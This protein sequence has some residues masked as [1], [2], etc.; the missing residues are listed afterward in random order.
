MSTI[1][2]NT[3]ENSGVKTVSVANPELPSMLSTVGDSA[4]QKCARLESVTVLENI[5]YVGDY[6][7]FFCDNLT[8]ANLGN[9]VDYLGAMSFGFCLNL[10]EGKIPASVHTL[11]GNP[12]GGFDK[13][14][15]KFD[16]SN[17]LFALTTDAT[18]AITI[19]DKEV[20]VLYAV[21][22]A[23]GEYTINANL[24]SVEAGA[25]AGNGITSVTFPRGTEKIANALF[26]NCESLTDVY[27]R[28][29]KKQWKQITIDKKNKSNKPLLKAKIHFE[30]K[31]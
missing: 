21:Y 2:P 15:I 24:I 20:T 31:D 6:A 8:T 1:G 11:G 26:M 7:F 18:G 3:F 5:E 27:Y 14:K 29:N 30:Y 25:L 19:T 23:T 9:K 16:E 12:Y 17:T 22:G 28:G 4:F 10:P 13:S